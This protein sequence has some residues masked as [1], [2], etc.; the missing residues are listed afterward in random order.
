MRNYHS[1][2]VRETNRLIAILA[3]FSTL[4][5]AVLQATEC[6]ATARSTVSVAAPH[7]PFDDTGLSGGEGFE[8]EREEETETKVHLLPASGACE[9]PCVLP[10]GV[11]DDADCVMRSRSGRNGPAIRGPPRA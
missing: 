5:P 7:A 2:M 9:R 10:C 4:L 11:A 1:V 3:A 6:T 8:E